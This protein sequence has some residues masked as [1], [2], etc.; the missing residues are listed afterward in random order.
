MALLLL[1]L[2][3]LLL[4]SIP[5]VQTSAAHRLTEHL[6]QKWNTDIRI[7]KFQITYDAKIKLGDVYI[8]DHH[9]D[10]L[11]ASKTLRTSLINLPGLINGTDIDFGMVTAEELTFRLRRYKGDDKDSFG[12][13]LD[14][15]ESEDPDDSKGPRINFTRLFVLHSK[16]SYQDYEV[17]YPEIIFLNEMDLDASDFIIHGSDISV[18]LN[19]LRA[20]ESR[21]IPV[22]RL[23]MDFTL[24]DTIMN[25][26]NFHLV[27]PESEING[28]IHFT[29]DYTMADF[30]NKVRLNAD[31]ANSTVSTTDLK[32]FYEE[33]APGHLIEFEGSM[34]GVLNDFVLQ[35]FKLKGVNRTSLEGD[36][37][38]KNIFGDGKFRIDGDYKSL[39]T[40]YYDLVN[41]LPGI[42]KGPLPKNLKE[43]GDIN[44]I[45]RL[46]AMDNMVST[47]G[48]VETAIGRAKLDIEL[49]NLRDTGNETYDGKI[50]VN[51]FDLGRFLQNP[52]VG[53]ASFAAHM[54]GKGFET[55]TLNSN[56][57]GIFSNIEF[58][59]YNYRDVQV[60]GKFNNPV[61]V[62]QVIS[63]DPNLDMSFNGSADVSGRKNNYDFEAEVGY[64]D[65]H[66]LNFVKKDSIA[67]FKGR[68]IMNM[69][70]KGID[71]VVG[72]IDLEDASYQNRKGQFDFNNLTLTSSYQGDERKIAISSPDI[73][74]G[75]MKG[76]FVLS[77][78][79][80]L[81][82]NAIGNLYSNYNPI[83]IRDDQYL[84]FDISIHH[85]IVQ[86][87]FPNIQLQPETYLRGKVRSANSNLKMVF[88]SPGLKI[89]DNEFYDVELQLDN[90]NPLFTTYFD[91]DSVATRNYNFSRVNLISKRISDTLYVHSEFKG[92]QKNRDE[93]SFN[94]S[95]TINEEGNSVVGIRPSQ[96]KFKNVNWSLERE[97]DRQTIIFDNNF[98]NVTVKP[99][100]MFHEDQKV[101]FSG[102]KTGSLTKDFKLNF[103][104]VNLF[105]VT[106]SLEDFEFGGILNGD[107]QVI[108][109]KGIYYPESSLEV[110]GFLVNNINYGDLIMDIVGNESLTS[111]SVN[112]EM[113]GE[114][115]DYMTAKGF[116]N[117]EEDN[118]EISVGINL[119]K[120]KI[121][122]LNAFGG[123]VISDIR[124]TASGF[125]HLGGSYRR[126]QM[127]GDLFLSHTGLKIPYLNVDLGVEEN[128]VVKLKGQEFLF[129][130]VQFT[131]TKFKTEGTL[132][133]YL[134]HDNFQEWEMDVHINAPERMLVLDTD[135]T[136]ESLYYGTAF[137]SGNA[138]IHGPFDELTI[139]VTASSEDGT[140][141]KIPLSEM[142]SLAS[143]DFIYF[144]TP[145]DKEA[146]KEGREIFIK[147]LK[148]LEMNFDLDISNNAE[149]EIV[150]DKDS[151]SGLRG[152]GA[153]TLLMEINTV[154][155][156][157]MWGDF[158][159]LEGT[160]D[161]HYAGLIEKEFKVVSGGSIT[162]DGS[163]TQANLNIKAMY[164]TE[165]NPATL[166][167]NPTVN[168][169]IPVN[170]YIVLTG[171]MSNVDVNFELE[172]PNLSSVVKSELEYRLSDRST[173]ELQAL[174]LIAQ[175]AFY[176]EMDPSGNT[177]PENL[178]YERAAG[179]FND[180]FSDAEDKFKVGIN[181]TKGNRTPDQDIA[182]RVGVTLS[183]NV[184][185]RVII[186]GRVG[187]P[188]GGLTHS[189]VVGN[190]EIEFLLNKEGNLRAKIFN[191]ESDIQYIGEDIGYTQGGGI[192]YSVDFDTFKE[193][194]RKIL[195]K[196]R[197]AVITKPTEEEEEERE[198]IVPDYIKFPGT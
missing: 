116:I 140:I 168:R 74:E 11:I 4:F 194:I 22:E 121:G 128:S 60:I 71:D 38:L 65:L 120:F 97:S 46:S 158:V 18:K 82:K 153:G 64:A 105:E 123:E 81:V 44:L 173:T 117:L 197:T 177:H 6:N 183:T 192:A 164:Q 151:G 125:V 89:A 51:N 157:N 119:D 109:D 1:L 133:G 34:N 172:Y 141:F 145:E 96:L 185:D 143:H 36:I 104:N 134:S 75:E 27:T 166:L 135:Y 43:M 39:K 17:N 161:F 144:L 170:I 19:A 31:F 59:G 122:V 163:P 182:D 112:A 47:Q 99:I 69:T 49:T 124:G 102:H 160:Y 136:E 21:G 114:H 14:K 37:A 90:T 198:S 103:E 187:V 139:D 54:K 25:F 15:L 26:D 70:G 184:S 67:I 2:I 79:P 171:L 178:L 130:K 50:N 167:E 61:F 57:N 83:K 52:K 95:H 55:K 8:G 138:R 5:A 159:V 53:K 73:V 150:I 84:D 106:P 155:K 176:S 41:L 35:N 154:G 42:L 78:I 12:M 92:G 127:T 146:R 76:D 48:Q 162:W 148:G 10:T 156:F 62:G 137:I 33:F 28:D 16:F 107:L 195:N 196:D 72:I 23:S 93:F 66:A 174:S 7:A 77:E 86:A 63:N 94:F 85:K 56:L 32:K 186:N 87:I 9:N 193:L 108:Q 189:V 169:S 190:V 13:F 191:R 131:D 147:K 111:Y 45:G 98:N 181:Y 126:P 80:D 68:V 142:E 113:K 132:S 188:I 91:I 110:E 115:F 40:N 30:E 20:M 175:G 165:A 180:I 152:K 3:L 101:T 100:V 149:I 29:Y 129:D 118:P 58:N 24:R 88:K 179:L